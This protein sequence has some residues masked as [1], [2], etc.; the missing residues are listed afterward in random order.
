MNNRSW[1]LGVMKLYSSSEVLI[2]LQQNDCSLFF[3][4]ELIGIEYLFDQTG[5]ALGAVNIDP[6]SAEDPGLDE[7][8]EES[9]ESEE[10]EEEDP[11]LS[12]PESVSIQPCA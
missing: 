6:D 1:K 4:G 2:S 10:S 11:T 8:F 7:G 5:Q 12:R 3:A 9:E